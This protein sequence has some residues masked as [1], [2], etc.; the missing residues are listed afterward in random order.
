MVCRRF[1]LSFLFIFLVSLAVFILA[2]VFVSTLV[3]PWQDPFP[4]Y[5]L[6]CALWLHPRPSALTRYVRDVHSTLDDLFIIYTFFFPSPM[7]KICCSTTVEA[8]DLMMT[9]ENDSDKHFPDVLDFFQKSL[10]R[11]K[12][13]SCQIA[14]SKKNV[15]FSVLVSCR[16]SGFA[17][18]V[19]MT[20]QLWNTN[21][22]FDVVRAPLSKSAS[23]CHTVIAAKFTPKAST[24]RVTQ[25]PLRDMLTKKRWRIH[26]RLT[27]VSDNE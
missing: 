6:F 8:P 26:F 18:D 4:L 9:M 7:W 25:H 19:R 23:F 20:I 12:S 3:F 27:S 1:W 2:L 5:C 11:V 15:G 16:R 14:T 13:F 10:I 21:W 17:R 24:R 22:F